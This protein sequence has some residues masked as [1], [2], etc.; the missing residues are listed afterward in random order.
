MKLAA[1]FCCKFSV[2]AT[3]KGGNLQGQMNATDEDIYLF[4]FGGYD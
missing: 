3:H 4:M 2:L 1:P